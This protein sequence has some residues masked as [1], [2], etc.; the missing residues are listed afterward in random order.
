M[1]IL[2]LVV[3]LWNSLYT[4][5][6]KYISIQMS[7]I[8]GVQHPYLVIG[9][10]IG[11]HRN[12]HSKGWNYSKHFG[13]TFLW[14]PPNCLSKKLYLFTFPLTIYGVPTFPHHSL[15]VR[16]KKSVLLSFNL[17][18]FY[19]KW[20]LTS[21][22]MFK[23]YLYFLY[24]GLFLCSLFIY[25]LLAGSFSSLIYERMKTIPLSLMLQTF[26]SRLSTFGFSYSIILLCKNVILC[27][28]TVTLL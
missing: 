2:L 22:Y 16:W 1:Y 20:D 6:L 8:S 13:V 12:I 4:L 21:L 10:H 7:H 15:L 25:F 24:S 14:Q 23:S 11:Q 19:H 9:Y 3:S 17:H 27:S 5:Y 28:Q 18:L 26:F